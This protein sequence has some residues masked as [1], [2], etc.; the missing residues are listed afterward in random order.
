[1]EI[2]RL[3]FPIHNHDGLHALHEKLRCKRGGCFLKKG[4]WLKELG[5]NDQKH[6]KSVYIPVGLFLAKPTCSTCFLYLLL[7][8]LSE[9]RR[10]WSD[11]TKPIYIPKAAAFP[12]VKSAT[13]V[14]MLW[15]FSSA[16]LWGPHAGCCR[17]VLWSP[18]GSILQLLQFL[19][20]E[21]SLDNSLRDGVKKML[22]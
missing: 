12:F 8:F 20:K 17:R 16:E 22:S 2:I 18:C 5:R 13:L 15:S 11:P 9:V 3:F 21:R 14:S 7:C 4:Y 1:M 10:G 19:H 6:P